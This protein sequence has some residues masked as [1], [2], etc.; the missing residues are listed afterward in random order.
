MERDNVYQYVGE[1]LRKLRRER[2]LTQADV[3]RAIGVSP[4]QFQ[5]YEDA[6]SRCSLNNLMLLAEFFDV[7]LGA[8]L[9]VDEGS[10][11]TVE[12]ASH[13]PAE[14]DLLARLVSSFMKLD[15]VAEKLRLVQLVEAIAIAQ[16][17]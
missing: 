1:T 16:R 11:K 5:K 9:P 13:A 6:Q 7:P 4:Q 2:N 3:A 14:A 12:V 15:D 10:E 8:L 17:K